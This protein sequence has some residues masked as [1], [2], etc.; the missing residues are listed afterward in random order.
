MTES[1]CHLPQAIIRGTAP[2][3]SPPNV[4]TQWRCSENLGRCQQSLDLSVV[5]MSYHSH[6]S[7]S[8]RYPAGGYPGSAPPAHQGQGQY[9]RYDAPPG[10]NP[11]GPPAGANPYGPPA[12]GN[13]YGPPAGSD[14]QLW[15]WFSAVD[16]D[17]S[18]SISV[19]ELQ[20][21]LV[22]GAHR[23]SYETL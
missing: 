5:I 2:P 22:N 18:G 17:R 11:Y 13:P 7:N 19:T 9:N 12:G 1:D 23:L 16:L 21:A 15:Q 8:Q 4:L 10:G 6:H 14:P 3:L 20:A